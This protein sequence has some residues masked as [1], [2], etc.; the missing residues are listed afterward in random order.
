MNGSRKAVPWYGN[1]WQISYFVSRRSFSTIYTPNEAALA[2]WGRVTHIC[3]GTLTTISSDNGLSPSNSV[4]ESNSIQH[5]QIVLYDDIVILRVMLKKQHAMCMTEIRSWKHWGYGSAPGITLSNF[6][7][8]N[9]TMDWCHSQTSGRKPLRDLFR[10][11]SLLAMI[12]R[13]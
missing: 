2:H 12:L 10:Q 13:I 8:S 6:Y 5:S 9:G 7:V 1:G 11:L 4:Y 3:V